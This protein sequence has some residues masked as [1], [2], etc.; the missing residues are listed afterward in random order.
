MRWQEQVDTVI[1]RRIL[2]R[3][4]AEVQRRKLDTQL[5]DCLKKLVQVILLD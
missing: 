2:D 1:M 5:Q 4:D 3:V